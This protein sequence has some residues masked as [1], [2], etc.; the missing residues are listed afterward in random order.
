MQLS[1]RELT[2]S[3]SVGIA[4]YPDDARS[5]P[6]LSKAADAD[7]NTAP[8]SAAGT[9]SSS[10][11]EITAEAMERLAIEN[12]LRR[13]L[14][15]GELLLYFQPQ[16]DLRGG[17]ILGFEALLRWNHPERGLLL[18]DQF[19][20]IA[21][22]NWV[23]T[24]PARSQLAGRTAAW[25]WVSVNV[26]GNQLPHLIETVRRDGRASFQAR[27]AGPRTRGSPSDPAVSLAQP[28][29]LKSRLLRELGVHIAIDDR[30]RLFLAGR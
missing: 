19:I 21:A 24:R 9:P 1:G 8:S 18:P 14:V 25:T 17:R 10:T 7:D 6:N 15:R 22:V 29:V 13:A 20:P 26:S 2:P 23:S 12:D 16:V 28:P 5:A 11:P 3:T 30:R 4:I 27:R